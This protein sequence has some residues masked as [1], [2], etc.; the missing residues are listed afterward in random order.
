MHAHA[1]F[2]S[3]FENLL[4]FNN[5][6]SARGQH[7][8]ANIEI[9]DFQFRQFLSANPRNDFKSCLPLQL[10][11]AI[12]TVFVHFSDEMELA[13]CKPHICLVIYLVI[14]FLFSR[15]TCP[16]ANEALKIVAL[17]KIYTLGKL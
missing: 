3:N 4:L 8:L 9:E 7:F 2:R 14:T 16:G 6:N 11:G 15:W 1:I 12:F 13:G 17:Q 5:H 10:N